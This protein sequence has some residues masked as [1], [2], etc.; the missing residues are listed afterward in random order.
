MIGH[1]Y[2][3]I[4]F[5]RVGVYRDSRCVLR[6]P[7]TEADWDIDRAG[8]RLAEILWELQKPLIESQVVQI[9]KAE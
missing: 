7:G 8:A 2:I 5:G 4:E 9:K 1:Y 6:L 3:D